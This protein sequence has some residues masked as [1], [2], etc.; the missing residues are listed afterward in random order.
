MTVFTNVWLIQF[1]ITVHP[2]KQEAI[3]LGHL[4]GVYQFFVVVSSLCVKQ[5]LVD[6]LVAFIHRCSLLQRKLTADTQ[7]WKVMTP[8]IMTRLF[9][10][11]ILLS[12]F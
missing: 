8:G 5:S 12:L 6:W 10:D 1:N 11:D 2:A 9:C 7:S 3:P 4:K